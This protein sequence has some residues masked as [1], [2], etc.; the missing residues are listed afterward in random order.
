VPSEPHILRRGMDVP[1][2]ALGLQRDAFPPYVKSRRELSL[3]GAYSDTI[4]L[5]RI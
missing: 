5:K 2:A 1:C 4:S 3:D